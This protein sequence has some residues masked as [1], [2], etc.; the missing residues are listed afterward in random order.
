MT[1]RLRIQVTCTNQVLPDLLDTQVV[2]EGGNFPNADYHAVIASR[3]FPALF[4]ECRIKVWLHDV[5]KTD[6][7]MHVKRTEFA[8][9]RRYAHVDPST[10]TR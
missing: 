6:K 9:Q 4:V 2:Y 3:E 8:F 7:P 5:L 10:R 1:E